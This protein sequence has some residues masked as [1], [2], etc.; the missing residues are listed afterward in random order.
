MS[1]NK[2]IIA[3]ITLTLLVIV[4]GIALVSKSGPQELTVSQTVQAQISATSHD[5]GDIPINNGNVVKTFAIKNDSQATLELANLSTSCMCTT[6]QVKINDQ[7]S[8]F[9]GMHSNSSWRG[10]VPAGGTAEILVE[11]DPAFHGPNSVGQVTRQVTLETN[12]QNHPKITFNLT[13]NVIK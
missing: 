9:F 13:A 1:S 5:W 6:A 10:Q 3:G 2:I 11:F 8:P 12:D 7:T 4:G